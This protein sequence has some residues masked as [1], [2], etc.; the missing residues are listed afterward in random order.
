MPVNSVLNF[1][2]ADTAGP[3]VTSPLKLNVLPWLLQ[4]KLLEA[5]WKTTGVPWCVHAWLNATKLPADI[6]TTIIPCEETDP[7]SEFNA[8]LALSVKSNLKSTVAGVGFVVLLLQET[9]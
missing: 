4:K 5:R 9:N 3:L 2:K 8:A 1:R 7:P 6:R